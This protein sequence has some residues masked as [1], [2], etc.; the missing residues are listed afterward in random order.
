[1]SEDVIT[2][3]RDPGFLD[4]AAANVHANLQHYCYLAALPIAAK[5]ITLT[6]KPISLPARALHVE[7]VE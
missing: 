6:V 2:Q 3:T 1:L 7:G 4:G 5:L